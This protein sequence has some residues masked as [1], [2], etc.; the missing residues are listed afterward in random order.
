[1]VNLK[2]ILSVKRQKHFFRNSFAIIFLSCILAELCFFNNWL[3]FLEQPVYEIYHRIA[4]VRPWYSPHVVIV[5]IDDET[6]N[7]YIDDPLV[8]WG[9]HLAKALSTIHQTKALA[10]GIDIIFS[11]SPESWLQK[12]E[13]EGSDISRSYDITFREQL[14][15]GDIILSGYANWLSKDNENIILPIVEYLY[16]L[17]DG[18]ASIGLSNLY[19]DN[20]GVIRSFAVKFFDDDRSPDT[21]FGPLLA[22]KAGFFPTAP[23]NR[24]GYAGPPGT[25]PRLS[26]KNLIDPEKNE[27]KRIA[28]VLNNKIIIISVEQEGFNDAHMTPYAGGIFSQ[29]GMKLMAGAEIHANIIESIITKK[30]PKNLHWF[31]RIL[32][33]T[34]FVSSGT[35]LS[36]AFGPRS[37]FTF[38]LC[39]TSI[40]ALFSYSMFLLGILAP[41][42]N[43]I[44]A[45]ILCYFGTLGIRLT[46]EEKDRLQLE[47]IFSPYVS[48]SLLTQMLTSEKKPILGGEELEITVMFSDIRNFT[49]LSEKLSPN[50]VV[51]MLNHYYGL[52]C[53]LI[54]SHGGMVDKF[55]GDAVMAIFGAPVGFPDHAEK[56]LK[57][58]LG[59]IEIS[60]NF[61]EWVKKRFPDRDIPEFKIGIGIHTGKALI[62]NIGS[63]QRMEYTAIGDTI[64][65]ASRLEGLCKKLG[66]A[67]VASQTTIVSI[68]EKIIIGRRDKIKPKGRTGSIDI[69][70]VLGIED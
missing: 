56:S 6:L 32:W 8:F 28:D 27:L 40:S 14:H 39:L 36:Q 42:I 62:G 30:Y 69:V 16:S 63:K 13:I 57:V 61:R 23:L 59:M 5:S 25:I 65:I 22:M 2:H 53:D 1:M 50:E 17:P 12:M 19:Q 67:I 44:L 58:A 31:M 46:Q 47:N 35:F 60:Q 7:K 4:K 64:N 37:G 21:A 49:T 38:V 45:L 9:P 15:H 3:S 10:I 48:E 34:I 11:V 29:K 54:T 43:V 18:L 52:I 68:Q 33:L 51:E 26:F 55:I 66:W 70:E 24:I 20:D 41:L